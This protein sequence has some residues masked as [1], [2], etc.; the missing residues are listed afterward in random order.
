MTQA[1]NNESISLD[2]EQIC[3]LTKK[4]M[5]KPVYQIESTKYK[6]K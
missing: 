4:I 1:N 6:H 2:K 3:L 5:E